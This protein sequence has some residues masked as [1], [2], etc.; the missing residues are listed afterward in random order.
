MIKSKF[1]MSNFLELVFSKCFYI[2]ERYL[3]QF[4]W[5]QMEVKK[6]LKNNS[7]ELCFSTYRDKE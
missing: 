2:P 3:V 5:S 7:L 6:L 1:F 4:L